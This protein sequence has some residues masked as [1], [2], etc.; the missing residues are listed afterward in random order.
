MMLTRIRNLDYVILLCDDTVKMKDFY[1]K[2][3]GF[4]IH[5][6]QDGWTEMRVGAV[7]L[8]LR[9][10]GRSYDGGKL[11]DSAGVQLAFRVSPAE[12]AACHSELVSKQVEILD[13]P[14]DTDYGHRTLFFKDPEGNILE[15]CADI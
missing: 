11:P 5:S 13:L 7:L 9:K 1:H 8:T 15:I 3:M 4:P 14:R 10:R 2:I 12:V 6:E